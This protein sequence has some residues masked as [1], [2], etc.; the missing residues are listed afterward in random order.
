MRLSCRAFTNETLKDSPDKTEAYRTLKS[1]AR[2]PI[3]SLAIHGYS[4]VSPIPAKQNMLT[5]EVTSELHKSGS[6]A[7]PG[8]VF[9]F[10]R[11]TGNYVFM[12]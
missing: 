6:P 5:L 1:V 10:E 2:S 12:Y 9:S 8:R 7:V 4:C 11:R 3:E